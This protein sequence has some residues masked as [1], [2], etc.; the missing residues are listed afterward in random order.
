VSAPVEH[1]RLVTFDGDDTLWALEPVVDAALADAIGAFALAFPH[2][3]VTREDL[4]ADRIAVQ[5]ELPPGSELQLYRRAAYRRRVDLLGGGPDSLV[6]E[7]AAR[8]HALRSSLIEPFPDALA[9]LERLAARS[10]L[11]FITNGN[12]DVEVTPF[13]GRFAFRLHAQVHGPGK[14]DIGMFVHALGESGVPAVAA[15]HVG[16]SLACDVAGAQAAGWK[17]V[18]LNRAGAAN[19][20]PIRPDAEIASLDELDAALEALVPLRA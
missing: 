15:V 19:D 14:P 12:A 17:A 6:D 2:A 5:D 9:A 20:T 3:P 7:L 4:L 13:A 1:A 10:Q 16:D 11:G 18:W 8:F